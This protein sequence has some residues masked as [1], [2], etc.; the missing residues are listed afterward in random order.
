M[1]NSCRLEQFHISFYKVCCW[2]WNTNAPNP[3]KCIKPQ[4]QNSRDGC[5]EQLRLIA[6]KVMHQPALAHIG[7][8]TQTP[9]GPVQGDYMQAHTGA[10]ISTKLGC[11][12]TRHQKLF[13][14]SV[15]THF[16]WKNNLPRYLVTLVL[17]GNEIPWAPYS[18]RASSLFGNG[19]VMLARRNSHLAVNSWLLFVLWTLSPRL[20]EKQHPD[21]DRSPF[22]PQLCYLR[23]L[24]WR[25]EDTSAETLAF[26]G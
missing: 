22:T 25:V 9:P 26:I 3:P 4:T 7:S 12:F 16:S 24:H 15:L 17:R 14:I 8:L 11:E 23:R 2:S 1:V 19:S 18:N 21:R 10:W 6:V 20:H 13:T 5:C